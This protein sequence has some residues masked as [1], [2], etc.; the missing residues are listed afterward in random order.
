[1]CFFF[2]VEVKSQNAY[3]FAFRMEMIKYDSNLP[4]NLLQHVIISQQEDIYFRPT[5]ASRKP[6][7]TPVAFV[8]VT[9]VLHLLRSPL[10]APTC[11]LYAA[12]LH[13]HP[14]LPTPTHPHTHKRSLPFSLF[15]AYTQCPDTQSRSGF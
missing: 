5:P 10:P 6:H 3:S 11:K 13:P 1:M 4:H 8:S 14:S 15:I 12:H 9:L 2:N 7:T